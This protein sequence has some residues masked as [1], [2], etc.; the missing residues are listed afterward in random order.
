M[1]AC[2]F[3]RRCS[4]AADGAHGALW[5]AAGIVLTR[6]WL[7]IAPRWPRRS[8]ISI[9]TDRRTFARI[10]LVA[11]IVKRSSL[12]RGRFIRLLFTATW[13]LVGSHCLRLRRLQRGRTPYL[14][15]PSVGPC[16]QSSLYM[17]CWRCFTF[18]W[19]AR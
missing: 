14:Q 13:R 1:Q 15:L 5:V 16:N 8:A 18:C 9:T 4:G 10:A 2:G 17:A 12:S 19:G 7:A 3:G 11:W 6:L